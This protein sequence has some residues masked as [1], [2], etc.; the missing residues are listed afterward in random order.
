MMY[1]PS[2][3]Y[4]YAVDCYAVPTWLLLFCPDTLSLPVNIL[5]FKIKTLKL[6]WDFLCISFR[7][8]W[9]RRI[10]SPYLFGNQDTTCSVCICSFIITITFALKCNL[11][12]CAIMKSNKL[13]FVETFFYLRNVVLHLL[14]LICLKMCTGF[15]AERE[16][17][18]FPGF[19]ISQ[20]SY[21]LS[22]L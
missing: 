6:Y 9:Q 19:L 21:S 7:M 2:E 5:F 20:T 11:D 22:W 17:H 10:S 16:T 13:V 8:I 12:S 3:K 18:Y 14:T 15:E 1:V 4:V